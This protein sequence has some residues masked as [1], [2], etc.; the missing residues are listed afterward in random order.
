MTQQKITP[1][2]PLLTDKAGTTL[3]QSAEGF[4]FEED[5]NRYQCP[6]GLYLLP[7]TKTTDR[8]IMYRSRSKDCRSCQLAEQCSAYRMKHSHMR[9]IRRNKHQV[10]FEE[11]LARMKTAIFKE[12]LIER[13]WKIEGIIGEAK[14]LHGLAR[15]KYRGLQKMQIQAY[16]SASILNIKRLV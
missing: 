5:N 16:L 12:R 13:F 15:A 10:L 4:L 3:A 11:T 7:Y 8:R 9:Y 1:Y 14:N 6:A 2:I